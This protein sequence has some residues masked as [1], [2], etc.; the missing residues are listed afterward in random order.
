MRKSS[1]WSIVI[2]GPRKAVTLVLLIVTIVSFYL[3]ATLPPADEYAG[4]VVREGD[5][6]DYH[7]EADLNSGSTYVASLLDDYGVTSGSTLTVR[8][9]GVPSDVNIS[10]I[11]ESLPFL[12]TR[13]K[14]NPIISLVF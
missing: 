5:E 2:A 11:T 7:V 12:S 14:T 10:S 8:A 3:L 9:A 4:W 13:L 1:Q 6:V